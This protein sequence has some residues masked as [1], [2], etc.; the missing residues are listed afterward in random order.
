MSKFTVVSPF[1]PQGDQPQAIESLAKGIEIGNRLQVLLGVTGSG[2]TYTMA[3]LIECVQKPTLVI[4]HNKTLAAQLC[5][6]FREFFPNNAVEYFVSYYDYYQ[7]EAYIASSDTYIEKVATTN[8][9]IDR[10]RHSATCSLNER[11]DVII[12]ASVSCIYALGD[13]EEYL[14]MSVSLRRGMVIDRNAILRK[15]VDIQYQR[16]DFEFS[17]GC[18]RV[19]GDVIEI[20]PM[21]WS[22]RAL[23]VEL[24]GD[25]IDNICEINVVTGTP[26]R[27]LSHAVI[28]PATHY[29]A[30][31][32]K[33]ENAILEIEHDLSDRLDELK[34]EGKLVEAQRLEQRTNYDI[35]MIREIGYCQGI[36]NYSRYFDGRKPG[37]PP[38]TLIDYFK[39][40]FLT[41]ID[42]SHVTIPQIRAMYRGDLARKTELVNYGFRIPSAFDNRPLTFDEFEE[43]IHQIVCVSATPA[44]YELSLASNVAEQIIRPTGLLDPSI[45]VRPVKGQIDDLIS[46]INLTSSRGYRT[47]V[48]TLTKRMAEMLTE[49]LDAIGIRV[50]YMHS[51]IETIERMEIIRDLRLGEFDALIGINLLREGLDLPEVGL[52]AILDADKEGFLR[53]TTSLIQTVGR[54]ARNAD[55]RVIMYADV[56]TD[57]MRRT[58]DETM[59]RRSKQEAYNLE[60]GITPTTIKKSIHSVIEISSDAKSD[61][62]GLSEQDRA[63]RIELLTEQ[64]NQAAMELEFEQ[65]SKLRDELLQL[66]G[67]QIAA[68]KSKP[69]PGT[70]GSRRKSR[71]RSRK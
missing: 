22:D 33:L 17:R 68:Q 53:S 32:D 39:G 5:S 4:A 45:I 63:A 65:A 61:S 40:D 38:F 62:S 30:G 41:I 55:G 9:E 29:A 26:I 37:Q 18:F 16:N 42:E 27:V 3:K 2:K 69:R 67:G 48:T 43:R 15:L 44:E 71:E 24:F 60:H 14:R 56:I 36:E 70:V 35:E 8:D 11:S 28:F 59:R 13:P 1:E 31:R 21:N 54:A 58:I 66:R 64:M 19:R 49:H 47:L 20:F 23:R 12:V 6:E 34:S 25:E 52:V 46:E 51:E 7:P 57:S 10:L 50:R